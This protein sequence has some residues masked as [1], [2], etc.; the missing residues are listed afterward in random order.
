MRNLV[1][2]TWL[3]AENSNIALHTL[4]H[5]ELLLAA[6]SS[7]RSKLNIPNTYINFIK[8]V[9]LHQKH[10]FLLNVIKH[11]S[12]IRYLET[13][14]GPYKC[15]LSNKGTYLLKDGHH[16]ICK[17]I[18]EGVKEFMMDVTLVDPKFQELVD[19]LFSIYKSKT[20]YQS[21]EHPYFKNWRVL[22]SD[23]RYTIISEFIENEKN[24]TKI[25][26]MASYT[27]RLLRIINKTNKYTCT[28]VEIDPLC[29][30]ISNIL[31][32]IFISNIQYKQE[33]CFKYVFTEKQ[34]IIICLSLLHHFYIKNVSQVENLL[35]NFKKNSNIIIL[36][37][38][39]ETQKNIYS[40]IFKQTPK[41]LGIYD[42]REILVYNNY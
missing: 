2:I 1:N 35:I 26:E 20:L 27:G 36:D 29:I 12:N 9:F 41:I 15:C 13:F 28:G 5:Y 21:I 40:K 11:K 37:S 16:R 3:R 31:N 38:I 39:N 17:A 33:D 42:N 25:T 18:Y 14:L 4:P 23:D 24:I 7:P 32:S 10:E 6:I 34:D 19:K 8:N 22:R 30:E